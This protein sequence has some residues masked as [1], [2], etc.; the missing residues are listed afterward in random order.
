M[1]SVMDPFS[2]NNHTQSSIRQLIVVIS[3]IEHGLPIISYQY[4][5]QFMVSD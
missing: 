1:Y 5:V 3:C 4:M 2:D